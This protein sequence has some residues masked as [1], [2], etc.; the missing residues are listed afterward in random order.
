MLK[1]W[2]FWT[3]T[4]VAVVA[5]VVAGANAVLFTGNQKAQNEV[6]QRAQYVQQSVQLE[7]LYREIVNALADLSVRNQD[8]ALRD[9]LAA[10]GITVGSGPAAPLARGSSAAEAQKGNK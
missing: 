9:L 5:G 1:T 4:A 2:E 10:Q 3:L 8:S 7:R 6:A